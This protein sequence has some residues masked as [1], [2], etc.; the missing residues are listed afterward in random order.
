[1]SV[2]FEHPESK[3]GW[4]SFKGTVSILWDINS[5]LPLTKDCKPISEAHLALTLKHLRAFFQEKAPVTEFW[6]FGEASFFTRELRAACKS[7]SVSMVDT[8]AKKRNDPVA[9]I[10]E[11][12]KV[13]HV[14]KPPH[15]IVL[16]TRVQ[17]NLPVTLRFLR[18]HSYQLIL[19]H[20]EPG[21]LPGDIS[22][23]VAESF[24]WDLFLPHVRI[25]YTLPLI[26]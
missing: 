20:E 2:W 8:H 13:I 21:P 1:M 14:H 11:L 10:V 25:V 23:Q 16:V 22:S 12:T 19:L 26:L 3:F 4:V 17:D 7:A 24:S 6:C 18:S 15:A 5:V 9:L